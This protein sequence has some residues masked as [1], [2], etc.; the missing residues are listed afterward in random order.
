[1]PLAH[2]EKRNYIVS[3][4]LGCEDVNWSRTQSDWLPFG[5]SSCEYSDSVKA[6]HFLDSLVFGNTRFEILARKQDIS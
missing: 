4:K 3:L 1:M 2:S 5:I 6:G